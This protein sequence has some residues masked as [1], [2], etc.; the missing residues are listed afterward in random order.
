[1]LA[2][3]G[4]VA[5]PSRCGGVA[6]LARCGGVAMLARCGPLC[7]AFALVKHKLDACL[8]QTL[9]PDLGFDLD[10]LA[11]PFGI[12]TGSFLGGIQLYLAIPAVDGFVVVQGVQRVLAGVKTA[13]TK[14]RPVGFVL[15]AHFVLESPAL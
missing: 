10:A 13:A 7:R 2:R 15:L 1:M 8:D 14:F 9:Q 12:I 11:H 3:C 5:T 4:G 6:M